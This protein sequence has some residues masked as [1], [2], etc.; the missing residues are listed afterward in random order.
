MIMTASILYRDTQTCVMWLA[1]ACSVVVFNSKLCSSWH[2][3]TF[4][5]C[6]SFASGSIYENHTDSGTCKV[7]Y[8][9]QKCHS[10][11][12]KIA[13]SNLAWCHAVITFKCDINCGSLFSFHSASCL[14]TWFIDSLLLVVNKQPGSAPAWDCTPGRTHLIISSALNLQNQA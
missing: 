12:P 4:F 1:L 2:A 8:C 9:D 3:C 10:P 5:R 7:A 14:I 6:F 11:L 13:F